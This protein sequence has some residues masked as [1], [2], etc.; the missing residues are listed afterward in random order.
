MLGIKTIWVHQTQQQT[1][2]CH[3]VLETGKYLEEVSAHSCA[4]PVICL[5]CPLLSITEL[6]GPQC[7]NMS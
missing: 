7:T 6:D 1:L 3:I 5:R 4:D 2:L